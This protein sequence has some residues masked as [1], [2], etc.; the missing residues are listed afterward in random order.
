MNLAATYQTQLLA[1]IRSLFSNQPLSRAVEWAYLANPRHLFVKRYRDWGS[2]TWHEINEWTLEEHLAM[3]YANRSL[4]IF[5]EDDTCI[6]STISQPSL[7]LK[8]LDLLDISPGDRIFELGGGSGWNAALMGSL[9][10]EKGRVYSLEIIPEMARM[11][12]ETH[13]VL[14]IRNVSTIEGDGGKGYAK[15][16]PYQRGIFTAGTY[17]LSHYFYEQIENNGLLLVVFRNEGMGDRIVLLQKQDCFFCAIGGVSPCSFVE[18]TGQ[19]QGRKL[20][21]IAVEDL[22]EWEELRNLEVSRSPFCW[23][24]KHS[25]RWRRKILEMYSFLRITEPNFQLF[26]TKN[27]SSHRLEDFELDFGFWDRKHYSLALVKD[28]SLIAYGNNMARDRLLA[29]L[30]HWVELGMPNITHFQLKI[31]PVD[32]PLRLAKNQWIVKRQESQFLW[33]LGEE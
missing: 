1:G 3:L 4:I 14:G 18:M 32:F 27:H 24:G 11:A 5:G 13:R 19:Y 23:L 29:R 21:A 20:G 12:A 10:G 15:G 33:S 2:P 8:M 9:V 31:Y 22:P 30:K 17:D 6:P 28:N 7:V 16:A 26:K 25:D